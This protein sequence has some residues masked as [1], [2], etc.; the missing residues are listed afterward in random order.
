ML[1][2]KHENDLLRISR[3]MRYGQLQ[4]NDRIIQSEQQ[5]EK[6]KGEIERLTFELSQFKEE[7][8]EETKR[9]LFMIDNLEERVID[10]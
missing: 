3:A 7:F 8:R 4:S 5:I 9:L 6:N 10:A 1:L 2:R